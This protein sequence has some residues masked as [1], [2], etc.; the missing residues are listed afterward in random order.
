MS[1]FQESEPI[2][3]E[4][5][6]T[7]LASAGLIVISGDGGLTL[8]ARKLST[9]G[10][11]NPPN[12]GIERTAALRSV[13]VGRTTSLPF[14]FLCHADALLPG[15]IG[16]KQSEISQRKSEIPVIDFQRRNAC[17]RRIVLLWSWPCTPRSA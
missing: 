14:L 1:L 8:R 13:V 17:K 12:A 10:F 6:S 9:D 3:G 4:P 16:W 11:G 15:F 2:L 7:L 5:L